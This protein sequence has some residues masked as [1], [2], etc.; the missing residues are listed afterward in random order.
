MSSIKLKF[1]DQIHS[2]LTVCGPLKAIMEL[3]LTL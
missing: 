2:L 3:E 1:I